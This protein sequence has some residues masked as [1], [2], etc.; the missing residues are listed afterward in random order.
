MQMYYNNY[1]KSIKIEHR[2]LVK[3]SSSFG[4]QTS[5]LRFF[6]RQTTFCSLFMGAGSSFSSRHPLSSLWSFRSTPECFATKG[7]GTVVRNVLFFRTREHLFQVRKRLLHFHFYYASTVV[8]PGAGNGSALTRF[9]APSS[10]NTRTQKQ[11]NTFLLHFLF[12]WPRFQSSV[13]ISNRTPP[14]FSSFKTSQGVRFLYLSR[15]FL[16]H[17]YQVAQRL[18]YFFRRFI[19]ELVVWQHRNFLLLFLF[20]DVMWQRNIFFFSLYVSEVKGTQDR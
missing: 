11:N 7:K 8:G 10:K 5:K 1:I 2:N 14:S 17:N 9:R 20:W 19:F 16:F 15:D 18:I 13:C 6:T 4:T 12:H 3:G